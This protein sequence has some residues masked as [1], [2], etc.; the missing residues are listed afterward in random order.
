MKKKVV[1]SFYKDIHKNVN[2]KNCYF[3]IVL[4]KCI[5]QLFA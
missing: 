2:Q 5:V 3:F 1:P 4:R